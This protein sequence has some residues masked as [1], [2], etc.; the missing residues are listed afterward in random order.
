MSNTTGSCRMPETIDSIAG[1]ILASPAPVLMPDTASLLNLLEVP[2]PDEKVSP[3]NIPA[4]LTI[5]SRMRATPPSL[6]VIL[7]YVVEEEWQRHHTKKQDT[8]SNSIRKVDERISFLW[9]IASSMSSAPAA[10]Y[11]QFAALRLAQR[12]HSIAEEILHL[13]RVIGSED[14]FHSAAGTRIA[15]D[16]APASAG[17]PEFADCVLTEQYLALCRRLRASG[18]NGRCI[19][20]S[21]NVH[22]FGQPGAPR[23]PLNSEFSSTGID[24]VYDFAAANALL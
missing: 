12:L 7:A 5:L 4:A 10:P 11:I 16:H 21:S 24:F 2:M 14:Q 20:V 19:F 3:N 22:D 18:C 15:K 6:H 23:A 13:A 8:V 9:G 1:I 17:K